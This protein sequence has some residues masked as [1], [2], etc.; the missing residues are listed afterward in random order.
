MSGTWHSV[1]LYLNTGF[2]NT[3][4]FRL[5]LQVDEIYCDES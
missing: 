5:F 3:I 2:P 4:H 1:G